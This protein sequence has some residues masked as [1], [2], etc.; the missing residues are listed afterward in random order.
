MSGGE[1][2]NP[3]KRSA[4]SKDKVAAL[5]V[6]DVQNDFLDGGALAVQG[7]NSI[8]P[9]VNAIMKRKGESFDYVI[10]TQDWHPATHASFAANQPGHQVGECIDLDG[11]NQVLWPVHCVQNTEGAEFSRKLDVTLFDHITKKG[12]NRAID[13]YS[14]FFDN[15][16]KHET[17]LFAYLKRCKV[18]RVFIL[19]LATDYCV[20]FTAIDALELGFDTWIIVDATKAVDLTPGDGE[21]ALELL[22]ARGAHLT[23]SDAFFV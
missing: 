23:K 19:G 2:E 3:G 16:Q 11:L 17:D 15:G 13:S 10:A 18:E 21:R 8:L 1:K 22:E 6:I 9:I 12:T 20:K 14:G 7:G 4:P 5:L